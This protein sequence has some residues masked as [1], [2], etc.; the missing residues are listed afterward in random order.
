MRYYFHVLNGHGLQRDEEGQEFFDRK[1]LEHEV[2]R[3]LTD[4]ARDELP[5]TNT[6]TIRVEVQD[7]EGQPVYTGSVAFTKRWLKQT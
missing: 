6:G 7:I 1:T 4:I 5:T 2:V 3:I